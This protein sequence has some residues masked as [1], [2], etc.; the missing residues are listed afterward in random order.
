VVSVNYTGDEKAGRVKAASILP[1]W[2]LPEYSCTV[3]FLFP[4]LLKCVIMRA[5]FVEV[6]ISHTMRTF[7]SDVMFP[8]LQSS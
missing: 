3:F 7:C 8:E 2:Y 4:D 6:Q 1:F 5:F